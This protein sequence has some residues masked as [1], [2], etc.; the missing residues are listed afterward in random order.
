MPNP[1]KLN[2]E[3]WGPSYWLFL[4][5][6]AYGYPKYPNAVTK[7]KYYDLIQNI[8]LFIPNPEIGN[9]FSV[10]LDKYPVTPYL[11]NRDS[12]MRWVNFI[13]NK[14]NY[15]L[16]KDE[17]SFYNSLDLYHM[18]YLPKPVYL[19][20]IIHIRQHLI[21]IAFILC[22]LILIYIYYE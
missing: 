4:H 11:D 15:L 13:H 17:I 6:I 1:E 2:P 21:H 18:E 7:R 9:K 12:F 14:I 19:S 22:C 3:I 5:T 10:M 8:P 16:G 20:E